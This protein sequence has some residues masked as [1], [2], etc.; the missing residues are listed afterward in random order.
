MQPVELYLT[1]NTGGMQFCKVAA[2][3]CVAQS[4]ESACIQLVMQKMNVFM[5]GSNLLQVYFTQLDTFVQHFF[6]DS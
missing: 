6:P 3:K 4:L 2:E 1:N 5:L